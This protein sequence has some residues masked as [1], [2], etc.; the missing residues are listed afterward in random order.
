MKLNLSAWV[1]DIWLLSEFWSFNGFMGGKDADFTV[2]LASVASAPRTAHQ[3]NNIEKN[4][5]RSLETIA[6]C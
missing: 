3:G 5:N 2:G 4:T 1:T 6:W